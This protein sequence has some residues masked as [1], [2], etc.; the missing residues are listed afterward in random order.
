VHNAH[1]RVCKNICS[2]HIQPPESKVYEPV[3]IAHLGADAYV[4]RQALTEYAPVDFSAIVACPERGQRIAALYAVAPR[5]ERAALASYRAFC[6][7]TDEQYDFL[8]GPTRYGGLGVRVETT[9]EDPYPDA[10]A[11]LHDL[12][13]HHRLKVFATA[14]CG[15][16][17]PLLSDEENDRFRAVHDFF[18]HAGTGRGFDQHGEEAAWVKH[19]RM[20]SPLARPGNDHGDTRPEQRAHLDSQRPELSRAEGIPAAP[21]LLRP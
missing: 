14:A 2:H 6:R 7:E 19:A 13:E 3:R 16:P 9:D 4:A 1:V 10:G 15:N 11:M 17:R 8:T 21:R 20:Y 18:G 12:T 5:L